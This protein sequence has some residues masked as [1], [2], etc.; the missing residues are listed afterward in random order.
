MPAGRLDVAKVATPAERVPEPNVV[1]PSRNVTVPVAAEGDT[2]A[3]KITDCP[4]M[5]GFRL[6]PIAVVVAVEPPP[7]DALFTAFKAFMRPQP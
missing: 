4:E 3:V 6:D 1:V 5:D 2:V 7:L